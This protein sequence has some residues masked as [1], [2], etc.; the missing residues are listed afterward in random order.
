ML[1]GGECDGSVLTSFLSVLAA[2][3][4]EAMIGPELKGKVRAVANAEMRS[5]VGKSPRR[6][7]RRQRDRIAG[8]RTVDGESNVEGRNKES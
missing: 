8:S 6:W 4:L 2:N 1:W 7:C 3:W 5:E